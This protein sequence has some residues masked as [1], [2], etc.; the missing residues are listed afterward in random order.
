[1]DLAR[2]QDSEGQSLQCFDKCSQLE[3][4]GSNGI[5]MLCMDSNISG[6]AKFGE[7]MIY[8]IR[9]RGFVALNSSLLLK[10][11]AIGLLIRKATVQSFFEIDSQIAPN[12]C[13]T[14]KHFQS[15]FVP[16]QCSK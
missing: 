7:S 14:K 2:C 5:F 6:S 11:K 1:L 15:V 16:L 4:G 3:F 13:L 9:S 8:S 10:W 12:G